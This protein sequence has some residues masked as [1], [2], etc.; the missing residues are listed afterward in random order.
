MKTAWIAFSAIGWFLMVGGGIYTI[1]HTQEGLLVFLIGL[2]CSGISI[3][4][5]QRLFKSDNS[6]SLQMDNSQVNKTMEFSPVP[7]SK[8]DDLK[9]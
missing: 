7:S 8:P 2:G 5:R 1:S 3:L 9:S 4:I 6:T